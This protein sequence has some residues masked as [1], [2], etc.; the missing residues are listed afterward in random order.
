[1]R[2]SALVL[3]VAVLLLTA[4]CSKVETDKPIANQVVVDK[5]FFFN[6]IP[7]P[8]GDVTDAQRTTF[9]EAL[10]ASLDEAK[11]EFR[12]IAIRAEAPDK[13]VIALY[14]NN[15]TRE[16]CERLKASK[17][18]QQAT[19]IGFRTLSC[20]DRTKSY[21]IMMPIKHSRGEIKIQL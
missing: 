15:V 16:E 6:P 17:I 5:E 14:A 1:M 2:T 3:T 10:E 4:S 13:V 9:A 11:T 7:F 18:I 8:S 21:S 12:D 20:Q 19:T